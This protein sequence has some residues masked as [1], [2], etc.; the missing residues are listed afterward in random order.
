M[1]VG[2]GKK[3]ELTE[4]GG[5]HMC[6]F[7]SPKFVY[8]SMQ[9]QRQEERLEKKAEITFQ[10][11]ARHSSMSSVATFSVAGLLDLPQMEG[12]AMSHFIGFISHCAKVLQLI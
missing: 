10:K 11:S 2:A 6:L 9:D 5:K 3:A 4:G 7:D 8:G 1:L 12:K